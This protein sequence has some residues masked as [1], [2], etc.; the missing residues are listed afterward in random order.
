MSVTTLVSAAA[1]TSLTRF[2][3]I[4]TGMRIL[5]QRAADHQHLRCSSAAA[6]VIEK[7]S[8]ISCREGGSLHA[9]GHELPLAAAA[10]DHVA[11]GRRRGLDQAPLAVQLVQQRPEQPAGL[12]AVERAQNRLGAHLRRPCRATQTPCP[13]AWKW[14]SSASAPRRSIVTPSSGCGPNTTTRADRHSVMKRATGI[15]PAL[16]AWKAPVPP[17][18][19]ARVTA[20]IGTA[21]A[22]IREG[23]ESSTPRIR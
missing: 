17:Q 18:H 8:S 7:R 23:Q 5:R 13:A 16:R 1:R 21:A 22:I 2:P 6:H 19:F 3:K 15:E 10:V 4:S 9:C 12:A 14:M 20:S 11:A